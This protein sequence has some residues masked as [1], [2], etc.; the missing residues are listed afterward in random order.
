MSE[1]EQEAVACDST[2]GDPYLFG[3]QTFGP[4]GGAA[5]RELVQRIRRAFAVNNRRISRLAD[6]VGVVEDAPLVTFLESVADLPDHAAPREWFRV[7][8][9]TVS[10]RASIYIGNGPN[11]PITKITPT[12]L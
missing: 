2:L 10:E 1:L 3:T 7:T 4:R 5:I 8:T 9:G 11:A 12:A 6:R